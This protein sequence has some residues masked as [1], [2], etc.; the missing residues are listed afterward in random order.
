MRTI[1]PT[2]KMFRRRTVVA[3]DAVLVLVLVL[4]ILLVPL[5]GEGFKEQGNQYCH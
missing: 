4:M 1:V 3:V 5:L 2:R